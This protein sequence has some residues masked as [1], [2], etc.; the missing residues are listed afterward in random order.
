MTGSPI[1]HV[2]DTARWVA[3][4]RARE[5]ERPDAIFR[6]PFARRLAG[7]EG[8][9][10]V[11]QMEKRLR[12]DWPMIVRTA[13][14][15]EIILR[16]VGQ[17]IDTVLNLACGLDARAWRLS[18]PPALRWIDVDMPGILDH[19]LA[20]LEGERPACVYEAVRLDLSGEPARQELFARVGAGSHATLVI[21]EG[22]LI[23]LEEMAVRSLARD[24][25]LVPAFRW[26]LSDLASPDLLR[27]MGRT[28]GK[29]M[30][31]AP[32]RFAPAEGPAWF[33]SA[34][35]AEN[36]FRS[37][38]HE[39]LRLDRTFPLARFWNLVSRFTGRQRQEKMRRFSG[40]VLFERQP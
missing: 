17:G 8:E 1:T 29:D 22:L 10:L 4:Y 16:L 11:K 14:M 31:Q 15:D 23:Y 3:I 39:G 21:T 19:K 6:D 12:G 25:H 26:W 9:A 38:F 33:A 27:M 13:V 7:T 28:W 5:S 36:E 18:L 24:L 35:W 2:S 34:G 37:T 20:T 40:I 30:G 32:F